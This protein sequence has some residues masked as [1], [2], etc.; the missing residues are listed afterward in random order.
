MHLC[1]AFLISNRHLLTAAQCFETIL[2]V[3]N[4]PDFEDYSVKLGSNY[5]LSGGTYHY[6]EQVEVHS[7]YTGTSKFS[8]FNV[9]VIT[10]IYQH[11][12]SYKRKFFTFSS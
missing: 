9:G 11:I 8:S 4:V 3:P 7:K 12:L 2:E 6:I 10:V 5:M 1:T